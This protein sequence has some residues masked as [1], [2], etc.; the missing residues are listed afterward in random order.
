[1]HFFKDRF[2]PTMVLNR[3]LMSTYCPPYW[4]IFGWL[5][6]FAIY[7]NALAQTRYSASTPTSSEVAKPTTLELPLS[8]T[9]LYFDQSSYHLR[10]GVRQTL[11]SM[12]QYLIRNVTMLATITA[13]TDNIG[14]RELNRKLAI[15]RAQVVK[16]YLIQQGVDANQ[17]LAIGEGPDTKAANEEPGTI[18]TISRRVVVQLSPR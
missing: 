11:D 13:Y 8:I 2:L 12:A 18:K 5:L 17:L 16:T 14:E 15:Q 4:S 7:T 9:I 3:W 6:T 1:M 10:P